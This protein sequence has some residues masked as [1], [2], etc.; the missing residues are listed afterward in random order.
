M[1]KGKRTVKISR[2]SFL[3]KGLAVLGSLSGLGSFP[4]FSCTRKSPLLPGGMVGANAQIGHLLRT[5]KLGVPT[6][7]RV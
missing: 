3:A 6:R 7:T 4:L 1:G 5:G 2:Q